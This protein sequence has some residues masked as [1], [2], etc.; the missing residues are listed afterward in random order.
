MNTQNQT[1]TMTP[2]LKVMSFDR[3]VICLLALWAIVSFAEAAG[4]RRRVVM[5]SNAFMLSATS[6]IGS[7]Y[8]PCT[9]VYL[10]TN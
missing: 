1:I 4:H 5:T 8:L 3:G 10:K 2:G 6:L 7:I 9:Y